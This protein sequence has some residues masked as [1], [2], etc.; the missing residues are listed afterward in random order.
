L[1]I[2]GKFGTT[3][4]Q[5]TGKHSSTVIGKYC[6]QLPV[7]AAEGSAWHVAALTAVVEAR[8]G[9]LQNV[10]GRSREWPPLLSGSRHQGRTS[11]LMITPS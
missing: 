11:T 7:G 2:N 5:V 6:R 8:T 1:A 10:N 4:R 9:R 3:Q